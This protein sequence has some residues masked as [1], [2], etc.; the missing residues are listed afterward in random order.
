MLATGALLNAL[1]AS[2]EPNLLKNAG[3]EESAD[4]GN[5]P[6]WSTAVGSNGKPQ[7][8]DQASHGGRKALAIPE[9]TAVEQKVELA[10]AGAYLARAWVKS[11]AQQTITFVVQDTNQPWVGYTCAEIKVPSNQWVQV[12]AFCSLDKDGSL[13]VTLGGVSKDFRLYHGVSAVMGS[14]ILVDDLELFRYQPGDGP[15]TVWEVKQGALDW[16]R[17]GQWSQVR[18]PAKSIAGDCV[19]QSPRLAGIVRKTDGSLEISSILNGQLKPRCTL[20]PSI[21]IP[22]ARCG[23][24]TAKNRRGIR[25]SSDE[26]DRSY[27]AWFTS[28]GLI[29]L[30]ADHIPQF[31]VKDCHL[32]YGLLPSFVGTDICY[33]PKKMPGGNAFN[34]P[35]TQWLVGLVDGNDSMLVTV[36]ESDAQA[37][38]MG[39]V[40]EGDNRLIDSLTISTANAGFSLSLVEH[41][42]L[43]HR[44]DLKEDWLAEYVPIDWQRP[45]PAQWMC[46]F[47]VTPGGKPTFRQPCLNYSFPIA[48]A[49]T[50]VWATWFE[51]WN[52]YPF[53]FDGPRTMFHFEKSFIPNGEALIYFLQPAAAD[54]YSP[55]EIVQQALGREKA[56][57]LFDFD[58]NRLRKLKYSTPDE[59]MYDR[60]VCATTTRLFRIKKED[61]A[62]VG[63]NLATHLYEFI[64]EIRLRVD[65]Y[66]AFF[67]QTQDYLE[68]QKK[69]QPELND[70]LEEMEAMVAEAQVKSREIYA[71]SLPAVQEKTEAI[72][73]LLLEGTGDG[74]SFG[75]LDCR[76]TAG[77]QDDTCRRCSRSVMRLVQTAAL[78]CGDS[79]QKAVIAKHIWDQSR[80]ILR[81]P[82][83]WESRRTLWFFEP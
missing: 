5:P 65:D 36:W 30:A 11:E 22:A 37:V 9:Y 75:I 23:L 29:S 39:L 51:D 2:V 61:K 78:K 40:G 13:T 81:Q 15:V 27:T 69:A 47:F 3:F 26:G 70:Y 73:K 21:P 42:N 8:T 57:V 83:R 24:V 48:C 20:I 17:R 72:K 79:P 14:P 49:K 59:F 68:S 28:E 1:G 35:S 67:A 19:I 60:P 25:V 64:R 56:M 7:V 77:S 71:T 52:H 41:T 18:T 54:L 45:F 43:W 44:E 50:R 38:S 46:H 76:P 31:Q 74:F 58:A 4:K 63:V 12:E 82:T 6:H 32:R 53:F 66:G 80:V 33:A 62:T 10:K 34:L 55:C 16:S